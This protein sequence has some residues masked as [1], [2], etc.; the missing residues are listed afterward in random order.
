MRQILE[1]RLKDGDRV[2]IVL[3]NW[4]SGLDFALRRWVL[5][6]GRWEC[7]DTGDIAEESHPAGLKV[8]SLPPPLPGIR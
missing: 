1:L 6:D 4:G 3:D 8:F 5:I 7:L 2:S